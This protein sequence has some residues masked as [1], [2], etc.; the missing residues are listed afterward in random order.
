[1]G[2]SSV[3]FKD[4]DGLLEPVDRQGECRFGRVVHLA[5]AQGDLLQELLPLHRE[6][7]DNLAALF[8]ECSA[9]CGT[10]E[11]FSLNQARGL[12]LSASFCSAVEQLLPCFDPSILSNAQFIPPVFWE[13]F[14]EPTSNALKLLPDI[15]PMFA[16]II[17]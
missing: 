12:V 17:S 16:R 8:A 2:L 9:G 10:L 7:R 5:N 6:L 15:I 13:F 11:G 14:A 1:M 3:L 4:L